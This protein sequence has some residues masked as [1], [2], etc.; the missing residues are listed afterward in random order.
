MVATRA[1]TNSFLHGTYNQVRRKPI[2]SIRIN[3]L[4]LSLSTPHDCIYLSYIVSSLC[5]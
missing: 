3:A 4:A 5:N 1:V 2:T